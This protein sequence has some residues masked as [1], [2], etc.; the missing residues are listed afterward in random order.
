MFN[1]TA[2]ETLREQALGLTFLNGASYTSNVG[3]QIYHSAQVLLSHRFQSGLFFQSGYTYGKNIDNVSGSIS[4]D[5]LNGSAGRGG[6]GIYNDQSS[7]ALNRALSDLDRR[8]RLTIAYGYEIPVPKSGIFGSQAFQGWGVSGLLTFQSGQVFS[9]CRWF[10]RRGLWRRA[11]YTVG[12]LPLYGQA[13]PH[14]PNLH[15]R[16]TD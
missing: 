10:R 4:T 9:A 6:A 16:Y 7:P 14:P 15:P 12:D 1:T 5:E 8:H 11:G 13:D 3:N 2:N